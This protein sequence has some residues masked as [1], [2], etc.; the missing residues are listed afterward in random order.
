MLPCQPGGLL[1]ETPVVLFRWLLI[2]LLEKL[3]RINMKKFNPKRQCYKAQRLLKIVSGLSI[4]CT[5]VSAKS[6]L[7]F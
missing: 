7:Y 2:N 6:K 4:E 1:L 3:S 5:Q